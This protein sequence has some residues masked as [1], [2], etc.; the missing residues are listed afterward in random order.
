MA[1]RKGLHIQ[2]CCKVLDAFAQLLPLVRKREDTRGHTF[3]ALTPPVNSRIYYRG[4]MGPAVSAEIPP[5]GCINNANMVQ[6]LKMRS[7]GMYSSRNLELHMVFFGT[8]LLEVNS[9]FR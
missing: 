1:T 8:M 3:F 6:N 9:Q 2:T 5:H 7:A 4:I